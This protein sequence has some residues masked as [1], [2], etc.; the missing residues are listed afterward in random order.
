MNLILFV[1]AAS[2]KNLSMQQT[3]VDVAPAPEEEHEEEEEEEEEVRRSR[4]FGASCICFQHVA[5][6]V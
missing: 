2:A 3:V 6:C 4:V 5:F 1:Q